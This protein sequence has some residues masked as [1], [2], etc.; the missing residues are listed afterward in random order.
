MPFRS[1]SYFKELFL[2]IRSGKWQLLEQTQQKTTYVC[3]Q[4]V[5]G[6]FLGRISFLA[7]RRI[8]STENAVTIFRHPDEV[9]SRILWTFDTNGSTD[10]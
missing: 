6:L 8:K 5:R 4:A 1:Y 2:N 9:L 10:I 7:D 3:T